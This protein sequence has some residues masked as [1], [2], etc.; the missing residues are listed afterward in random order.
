[1]IAPGIE[2]I[3]KMNQPPSISSSQQQPDTENRERNLI[4]YHLEFEAEV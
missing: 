1:M 2:S 4:S 3:I